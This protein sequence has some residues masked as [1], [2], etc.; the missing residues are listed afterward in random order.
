MKCISGCIC[1]CEEQ[2]RLPVCHF[3]PQ[4]AKQP[5]KKRLRLLRR[6]APRNDIYYGIAT[7]PSVA[8]NDI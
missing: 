7:L 2:R 5:H 6:Y 8:R 1:Y 3:E 4:R